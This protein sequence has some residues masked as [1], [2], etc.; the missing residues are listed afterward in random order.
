MS[1]RW[2]APRASG[3]ARDLRWATTLKLLLLLLLCGLLPAVLSAPRS[4]ADGACACVHG[5]GLRGI[6]VTGFPRLLLISL[7]KDEEGRVQ[8]SHVTYKGARELSPML[9]FLKATDDVV[10]AQA[11]LEK[12][13]KEARAKE[14]VVAAKLRKQQEALAQEQAA[15]LASGGSLEARRVVTPAN[16]EELLAAANATAGAALLL[17]CYRSLE[18]GSTQSGFATS[19]EAV[20]AALAEQVRSEGRADRFVVAELDCGAFGAL[21]HEHK[22]LALPRKVQWPQVF[23]FDAVNMAAKN[24]F[25]GDL[26]SGPATKMRAWALDVGVLEGAVLPTEPKAAELESLSGD[27]LDEL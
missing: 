22:A 24:Q 11:A 16:F 25:P 21:C 18:P 20:I 6:K 3:L 27:D 4:P 13:E 12:A 19:V 17:Q 10:A 1:R 5:R 8:A 9:E 23:R 2:T 7:A 14:E 26:F 15:T